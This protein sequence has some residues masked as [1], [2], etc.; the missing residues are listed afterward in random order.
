M[1]D[2]S[3]ADRWTRRR[4]AAIEEMYEECWSSEVANE[5]F[6]RLHDDPMDSHEYVSDYAV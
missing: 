6:D 1:D 2:M 3:A 4:N 5:Q